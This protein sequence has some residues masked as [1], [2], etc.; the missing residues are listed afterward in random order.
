MPPIMIP[1]SAPPAP[2]PDGCDPNPADVVGRADAEQAEREAVDLPRTGGRQPE[3]DTVHH[4]ANRLVR[5][6]DRRIDPIHAL[7]PGI[8]EVEA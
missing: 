3:R 6:P 7:Q 1:S 4:A 2:Q 8:A 5:R